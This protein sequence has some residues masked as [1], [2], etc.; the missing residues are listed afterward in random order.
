MPTGA[1][2]LVQALSHHGVRCLFGMPGSHSTH[3]YDAVHRHGGIETVLCRNEQ[4]GA[5]MADGYARATGRP[6]VICTTAGPGAT[7]ALTGVAEAYADSTPVL[8]LAGQVNH[9]R[10]HEECGRYHELDLEGVFRPCTRYAATVMAND[11]IA[12]VVHEALQ[13]MTAGRPGPAAVILPQDLMAAEAVA[14]APF[15]ERPSSSVKPSAEAVRRA[16]GLLQ[17][18]ER[19]LVLAGGGAVSAN[20]AAEVKDLARR[21]DCPLISTLNGKGIVDERDPQSLGHARSVRAYP[22]LAQADV[23]VAIGCRFTEVFTWLGRMPIPKT[24]IQIDIDPKQ[25]GMNYPVAVGVRADA[26]EALRALLKILPP[27]QSRWQDHWPAARERTHPKPEWLVETLRTELPE[28]AIVVADA[29]EMALRL[30]TDFP[31]YAPRTFFYPS[32]FI[33]LGWA[34]PAAVGAAVAAR[35]RPVVSVSGDGGFTMTAQELA[36]AARYRLKVIAVV[37][38]DST[39][40]AIKNLQRNRHEARL[41]DTDLNN[42]DFVLLGRAYGVPARRARDAAELAEALRAGLAH[43]GPSVIEVPDRWRPLRHHHA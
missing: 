17:A 22:L 38:N 34:F 10:L 36:T 23:M 7:N 37:H 3:L 14:D 19:P 35:D 29:C 21:L 18:S 24:L 16:A 9:D 40:G 20:A 1:D 11:Q 4:A 28:S 8:L 33:S 25:I 2:R 12:R 13:A 32:T 26:R 30:Q 5:F 41:R 15:D 39:Y 31:A 42:P 27:H 6:G 43:D